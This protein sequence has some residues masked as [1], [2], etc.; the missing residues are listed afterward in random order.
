MSLRESII[1]SISKT[2]VHRRGNW[3]HL[4]AEND[5]PDQYYLLAVVAP[6]AMTLVCLSG[7]RY[8]ENPVPV[9]DSNKL[10][11]EEWSQIGGPGFIYLGNSADE[12]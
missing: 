10:T 7:H 11:Q 2:V 1:S 12:D 5:E 9:V 6:Q 8:G 4:P 3:Y